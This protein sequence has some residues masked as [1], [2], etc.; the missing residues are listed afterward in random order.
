MPVPT[1]TAG[2]G[3]AA[4][5]YLVFSEGNRS[6]AIR[7]PGYA[8]NEK[9]ARIEYRLPD[10]TGN[11]Y[12]VLAGML[13]AGLDGIKNKIGPKGKGFGPYDV[14]VYELSD[15]EKKKLKLPPD[16]FVQALDFLKK[17]HRFLLEGDV[18]PE[19]IIQAYIDMKFKKEINM[20]AGRPHPYEYE[21][22]YD[23]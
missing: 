13:M 9:E 18:F 19:E 16:T 11:P 4:P 7:I 21:L 22:Y 5:K 6:S 1:P 10:T 8:I 20:I 12:L 15:H 23:I 2:L 14:N 17:D 3:L